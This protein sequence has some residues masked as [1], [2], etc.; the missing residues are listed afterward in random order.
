MKHRYL[1]FCVGALAILLGLAIPLELVQ[2]FHRLE[3]LENNVRQT[4]QTRAKQAALK[5]DQDLASYELLVHSIRLDLESG[6]LKPRAVASRVTASLGTAPPACLRLGVLFEP[7]LAD[8]KLRLS[9]PY[10]DRDSGTLHSYPYETVADYTTKA[11]F[12]EETRHAGWSE[13]HSNHEGDG[14]M[15]DYAEPFRLPGAARACGTVRAEIGLQALSGLV[16]DAEVGASSYGFLLSAKGVFL[17]HPRLALVRTGSTLL[18]LAATLHDP[19]RRLLAE[20]ALKGESGFAEGLGELPAQKLWMFLEP[21]PRAH[22]SLGSVIL[23][24][25]AVV[26]P[27]STKGLVIRLVSLGVGLALALLYLGFN[28]WRTSLARLWGF[29]LTSSIVILLG[30]AALW[31]FAYTLP[32]QVMGDDTPVVDQ[33]SLKDFV[34]THGRLESGLS[35]LKA[36][37][38][39]TGVLLETLEF[40]GSGQVQVTGKVWQRFDLGGPPEARGGV[41]FPEAVSADIDKGVERQLDNGLVRLSS[42]K[43]VLKQNLV[44]SPNYPFDHARVRIWIRPKALWR[45]ELLVPDLGAY[46]LLAPDT[47]PGVDRELRV[48]GWQVERSYFSYLIQNYNANFGMH[49]YVGQQNSPELLFNVTMKRQFLNPFIATFLP[50]MA[51][52][53]LLFAS[54]LT[55]SLNAEKAK[56]TGYQCM[57]FQRNLVALLFPVVLAQI[58]LRTKIEADRLIFLEHYY[59]VVYALML[60]VS[61]D[62]L[63]FALTENRLI[64]YEDNALAK[65]A[66]WPFLCGCFYLVTIQFLQ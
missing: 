39:P 46:L 21:V 15:V 65:L 53:G 7:Y 35:V 9:G 13:G 55:I 66:F 54:M 60:L 64:S 52:L 18:Q 58:N 32:Q 48:L 43:V 23:K 42:F 6:R 61:A 40:I 10:A 62:A 47:L 45:D 29:A 28:G 11:W 37:I 33:A 63:L 8:P 38:I 16:S 49:D 31:H 34:D 56:A 57:N 30:I 50:I 26:L 19:G 20:R 59:F 2:S 17:A 22:W 5:V 1:V 51:V 3:D 14:L 4:G 24:D 12:E 44:S 36:Q 25:E 27:A 41:S